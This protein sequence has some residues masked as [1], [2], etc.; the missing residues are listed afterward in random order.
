MADF[1]NTMSNRAIAVSLLRAVF[2]QPQQIVVDGTG[3]LA[4]STPASDVCLAVK[5]THIECDCLAAPDI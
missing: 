4:Y 2:E 5:S 1:Y 3:D